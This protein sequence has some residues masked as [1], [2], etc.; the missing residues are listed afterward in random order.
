[1]TN[2]NI[3]YGNHGD[4]AT[5]VEDQINFLRAALTE[6]GHAV[7]ISR[8]VNGRTANIIIESFNDATADALVT[9]S[10]KGLKLIVVLTELITGTTFNNFGTSSGDD[11][12][13]SQ[14]KFWE[15]RFQ[16]FLRV[17]EVATSLW[18]I[19]K[20]Q[21]EGY[22]K[23]VPNNK[24]F[25][26]PIGFV[27]GFATVEHRPPQYKNI[28]VL[29]TG[30][31]T[32]RRQNILDKLT[33]HGLEVARYPSQTASYVRSNLV[34]RSKIC[35]GLKQ[36]N[37]W[38]VPSVMRSYYHL[39]TRSFI[40][41]ENYDVKSELDSYITLVEP[42]ALFDMCLKMLKL[43]VYINHAQS[44]FERFRQERPIGPMFAEFLKQNNY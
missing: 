4:V 31:M 10:K 15:N 21:Y 36:F 38:P 32:T 5:Q 18:Y 28:D 7:D 13:Y 6:A 35:L 41:S 25:K 1:M 26:L 22:V 40:L 16:N 24:L 11:G 14:K 27:D 44:N 23:F 33:Q 9:A 19:T 42:D 29:F 12:W 37:D 30:S 17:A 43:E 8:S 39:M 34:S 20:E 2:F 3:A